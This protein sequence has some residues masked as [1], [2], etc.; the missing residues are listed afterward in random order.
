M[1]A[2]LWPLTT[3]NRI[4][5]FGDKGPT[6][7]RRSSMLLTS[8]VRSFRQSLLSKR[9]VRRGQSLQSQNWMAAADR[10][11]TGLATRTESLEERTLLTAFVIDQAFVNS[12]SGVINITNTTIDVNND[13]TP[14]FDSIV[15]D[16]VSFNG[17]AGRGIN[18]NLSD[19][20]LDRISIDELNITGTQ[21]S[22]VDITLN[23]VTL[24]S[25][26][27]QKSNIASSVGGGIDLNLTD[28]VL[29]VLSVYQST[30][31]V[32]NGTGLDINIASQTRNSR[33]GELDISESVIDGVSI[34]GSGL[35]QSVFT[36]SG[37][38]P[39]ALTVVDH[40]LQDGTEVTVTGVQGLT[41]A[42]TI[43]TITGV[44]ENVFT[45]DSTDGSGQFYS[46]GGT[47]TVFTTVNNIRITDNTIGISTGAGGVDISLN[48]TR[49]PGLII[50]GNASIRGISIS[51][52]DSPIDGLTV[53]D[54]T[55]D[56]T[57]PQAD[58]LSFDLVDSTLTNLLIDNNMIAGDATSGGNGVVFTAVD[59]N[60]YGSFTRTTVDR[61]LGNALSFSATSTPAFL[62]T[63]RGPLVFDFNSF[64]AETALTA[65][66]NSTSTTLVVADGRS[67]QPQQVILVGNEQMFISAVSRNTLTV[68]RGERGTLA[69]SHRVTDV[70]R[71][72]TSSASGVAR[73]VSGNTFSQNAGA[74]LF[75]DLAAGTSINAD[76]RG[77]VFS[78]NQSRA[79]DVTVRETHAATTQ[80]ARGG[81][82]RTGGTLRVTDASVFSDF[83]FPFNVMVEGEEFTVSAIDRNDLT[84]SRGV[85]E[86]FASLHDSNVDVI[87]VQ[88]DALR[89][90]IGGESSGD[91]N[92]LTDNNNGSIQVTLQ[93]N[94]AGSFDIRNNV[95]TGTTGVEADGIAINLTSVDVD[96][97]AENILRR[98]IIDSNLIGVGSFTTLRANLPAGQNVLTVADASAFSNGQN[99]RIDGEV[100]RINSITG[101]T[102]SVTRAVQVPGFRQTANSA[103]LA[104]AI[105]MPLTGA[106]LDRGIDF[107]FQELSAIED[108]HITNNIV[109]NNGDDGIRFFREDD[110]V[111]RTVN[112]LVGQTTAVTISGNTVSGNATN[113]DVDTNIDETE[114][115]LEYFAAG[116]EIQVLNGTLDVFD[117]TISDNGI[118]AN[119]RMGGLPVPNSPIR[120]ASNVPLDYSQISGVNLRAEADA[121]IVANLVGNRIQFNQ[122]DGV[123]QSD[124]NN[125]GSDL[126]DV[127]ATYLTNV[128]SDN[129]EDGI[130][131]DSAVGVTQV[132]VI[133]REGVDSNGLSLGNDISAN[134]RFGVHFSAGSSGA[135]ASI[136]NNT[137]TR[138]GRILANA[139]GNDTTATNLS[140]SLVF[141]SGIE[142]EVSASVAIKANTIESNN[143]AGIDINGGGEFSVRNNTIQF[144]QNDGLELFGSTDVVVL[145]NLI[146]SNVGRGVDILLAG[147]G[148]SNVQIGDGSES[149][150]NRVI[151]N[152]R[153]AIY[154]VSTADG[155]QNQNVEAT[156]Q[157][158]SNGGVGSG[159][160]AVLHVDTN[161]IENNGAGT[162]FGAAG[163]IV[164]Q[165]STQGNSNN[166][167]ENYTG[168]PTGYG[169]P[170]DLGPNSRTNTRVV[171]NSFDGN[172][173]DDVRFDTFRS[174]VDPLT[175]G[176]PINNVIARWTDVVFGI[177]AGEYYSDP[178]AR[179]NV[180]FEGNVGHGLNATSGGGGYSNREAVFKS[181]DR[182]DNPDHGDQDDTTPGNPISNRGPW[183][184]GG[185]RGRSILQVPSRGTQI[186][187]EN[188]GA[189]PA[190]DAV[191]G[192]TDV[193]PVNVA[194]G[195]TELEVTLG[196]DFFGVYGGVIPFNDGDFVEIEGVNAV[197]GGIHTA[198]G[199]YQVD[200][201]DP[202]MAGVGGARIR[203]RNTTNDNG[204]AYQGGGVLY[205]QLNTSGG[206]IFTTTDSFMYPG[207][208]ASTLRIAQG[209]DTAGSAPSDQF[210]SGSNFSPGTWG[211]WSP[212]PSRIGSISSI[213]ADPS[214][215][216]SRMLV[217]VPNHLMG[218]NRQVTITGVE[219]I[220][221]ANGTFQITIVDANTIS[222]PRG[223]NGTYVSG[224]SYE[225]IDDSFPLPDVPTFPQ[226][227]VIDITPDPRVSNTGIVTLTFSEEVTNVDIDDLF[228]T[229]DGV[230]IDTSGLFVQQ[231]SLSQYQVDF[232]SVTGLE[233]QYSLRIDSE[234]PEA[235]FVRVSPNPRLTPVENVSVNFTEDV[236]GV[237][238][239]DFTLL[240][241][242][243]D[244]NGFQPVDLSEVGANLAVFPVTPSQYTV[245]VSSV[246]GAEGSYRLRLNAPRSINIASVAVNMAG[247]I[248]IN[249]VAHGLSTGQ[250]L[251]ISGTRGA[252]LGTAT[253]LN[254]TYR[255][256]V[257]DDDNF[258]LSS[259]GTLSTALSADDTGYLISNSSFA[260]DSGIVD[261]VGR[262]YS[263]TSLGVDAS[264]TVTWVRGSLAPSA[265]IV[266]VDP[267]PRSTAVDSVRVVFSEPVVVGN[268]NVSDFRLSR[269]IGSGQF[270]VS[271]SGATV[272]AIDDPGNG[273]ATTFVL[274]GLAAL[275]DGF[276]DYRLTLITNDSTRIQDQQGQF[277]TFP[278]L[279]SW[280]M[281]V[282]EPRADIIDVFPDPRTT[283]AG[284]VQFV[285]NG[286]DVT[287]VD[288]LNAAAHFTLTRDTGNGPVP[289]PLAGIPITSNTPSAYSLDLSSV[290][291]DGLGDPIDG[292]YVLTLNPGTGI[293]LVSTGAPLAV[294]SADTWIQD[295]TGPR[296]EILDI[297]PNPRV[298]HAGAVTIQ[299]DEPV[300]GVDVFNAATDFSLTRD[301]NDGNGP[302]PVSLVG[303]R[304]R[305]INSVDSQGASVLPFSGGTVFAQSY[306]LDLSRQGL[307]DIDGTYVL[308]LRDTGSIS[309]ATG[310]AYVFDANATDTWVLVP[311]QANDIIED[312]VF[313]GNPVTLDSFDLWF[314]DTTAPFVV[315]G[316]VTVDPDPRSTAVGIVTVNFSEP[317]TG[318]NLTDFVL[319]RDAI[320][321]PLTALA[322]TQVSPSRYTIDL[323]LVTGAAGNYTLSI[324]RTNSLIQD[325][326]G[327]PIQNGLIVLDSWTV[328]N[329]GPTAA[330]SIT[331]NPRTTPANNLVVN[332]TKPVDVTQ[333]GLSDFRLEI[334]LGDGF[335]EIPITGGSVTPSGGGAFEDT[336]TVDLSADT[337][338]EAI[339]R[340][341]LVASDSEITDQAGIELG[342]DAG[343][344]FSIDNTLPLADI[345]DIAPDP[346]NAAVGLVNI[347]FNE[348]VS[349]LDLA[350]AETDFDLLFDDGLGGGPVLVSLAS[351][352]VRQETQ[353]RYTIDLASV[354]S[355][356]GSY[357][358]RL[359]SNTGIA[360]I[361]GNALED[362]LLG[363]SNVAALDT[364]FSG[365]DIV[366]PT[367][368]IVDV[369]TPRNTSAGV[370]TINFSEDVSGVDLA[371]FTLTRDE[372]LGAGPQPV[373]IS[374]VSLKNAPGSV[375]QYLLDL[376]DVTFT[377]GTFTLSVVTTDTLSPI[378]D[379]SGNP[380]AV[381][382][383]NTW[384]STL[385]DLSAMIVPVDPDPRLRSAGIVT[386]NFSEAVSGVGLEDFR[387]TRDTGAGPLLV[388]LRG[389]TLAQS[390]S[391]ADQYSI[392]L[393]S[394]TGTD[395]I[396]RLTLRAE[397]S[398]IQSLATGDVLLS[399]VFDEWQT[400]TTITVNTTS[401]TVDVNPG[402][403]VVA[404]S[405]NMISLRAA[406]MESGALPGDDTIN[407]PAGNYT[408]SIGGIGEQFAASGDLDITDTTGTL[409][410]LGAGADVTT[411]D[412]ASIERIFH[413]TSGA[414]LILDGVTI[415]GGQVRGSED[416]GGIRN[417]GGTVTIRNSVI[418]GNRSLDDGG[419][420]DNAGVMTLVDTTVSGNVATNNG[421]GIRNVGNLTI[422][423]STIGGV[424][425]PVAMTDTRNTAG[426]NGGGIINLD[427]GTITIANST[428][429]G[430]R[431]T[432]GSGGG[433]FNSG[434]GSLTNVTIASN[435][436]GQRGGGVSASGGSMTVQ[437]TIIAGNTAISGGNDVSV[438]GAASALVSV[439]NNLVQDINGAVGVFS[440]ANDLNANPN[441]GSLQ[442][443]GGSTFT[444]A[445]T[446]SSPAVD[447]GAATSASTD[448]RGIPRVLGNGFTDIGAFEFGGFFVDSTADSVDVNPGDGV[449]SDNFGRVTLR[450][451]I[452]EANALASSGLS[453]ANA[454]LLGTTT[455]DLSLTEI[456]T[457][458]PTVDVVDITPDPLGDAM[459]GLDP[460]DEIV[461][462]FDE[463]VL[464]VDL[465]DF[466]LT[467]EDGQG[468]VTTPSLA[469]AVLTQDPVDRTRYTISGL[470]NV[471]SSDGRYTFDVLVSDITDFALIPLA[472]D[473][474]QIGSGIAAS[475]QFV[476]GADVFAPTALLSQVT[477]AARTTNPGI[478]ILT[479]SEDVFGVST[480]AGAPNFMLTY[481]DGL[482][483][484]AV[485]VPL[486]GVAVQL[487]SL[488]EYQ[489]D[490]S[491][492]TAFNGLTDPGT[493]VLTFDGTATVIQDAA[494]NV[495]AGTDS[496][497]WVVAVD[498][499]APVGTIEPVTPDPRIGFVGVVTVNFDEPVTGVDL[500][501]AET[502]FNLTFD[503]DLAGGMVPVSVDLSGLVVTRVS[504]TQY[505]I[506]LTTV[507]AADGAYVF[508]L[509]P[510]GGAITDFALPANSLA[511]SATDSWIVGE[512]SAAFG[513]LDV[514]NG[515]LTII[516]VGAGSSIVDANQIDR[517]FDVASGVTFNLVDLTVTG[518]SV[519]GGK[520][521]GGV[522]SN[523]TVSL[524]G[525]SIS[526]NAA[527]RNG[528]GIFTNGSLAIVDSFVDGNTAGFGGG[529][530]NDD[531]SVSITDSTFAFNSAL[532]DG[533]GLF[534]DRNATV[535]IDGSALT[536]NMAG[537]DGGGLYNNDSGTVT[538]VDSAI[539]RNTAD[540][541]GGGLYNELAANATLTNSTVAF[542]TATDGGGVFNQDGVVTVSTSSVSG[543]TATNDGGGLFVTSNGVVNS[544][545]SLFSG[546]LAIFNGGGIANSGTV[547]LE[548]VRVVDNTADGSG[549][550]ISNNRILALDAS[551]VSGN[552]AFVNGGGIAIRGIGSLTLTSSA[553][554]ENTASV[555]GGGIFLSDVANL[556]TTFSTIDSN[557][558]TGFGGGVYQ[559]STGVVTFTSSTISRN[560]ASVGGGIFSSKGYSLL[561]STLS[562]NSATGNGGG[563]NNN[564]GTVSLES[565]TVFANVAGGQGGG[566]HNA[567]VFGPV[568]LRNTI[569]A[570]NTGSS[571][572]D[573]SGVQFT[574]LGNNLVGDRGSV[575]SFVNGT[576]GDIVGTTGS[577]ID[578]LLG[579]LQNNG[580]ATNTHSLL[581]GSP[582]RD[583]GSN[584]GVSATDQRGF[585]RIFDGDGNGVA[586]VD[587]GAFESG[588]T[589]NTFADTVDVRP[590]DRSS[591]DVFG[592]SSLRAAV[593]EA[594][595]LP[596]DDT[597]LLIP[598]TY[599]LTTAGRDE[600]GALTGDL[601]VTDDLTIIGAG[602]NQTFIDAA[603]LDRIFHVLPGA[604]LDLQNLTIRNGE[605]LRGGAVLN[606]GT[607]NLN[608]VVV[609]TSTADIGGGL[610][611]DVL[612]DFLA[613]NISAAA[614]TL[615]LSNAAAFPAT[616]P[617]DI[618]IGTE[619]IRVTTV[620]GNT[621]TVTR[622]VNSTTPVVHVAGSPVTLV[623]SLSMTDS[624]VR[625]NTARLQGGGLFNRNELTLT[626]VTVSGNAS[627]AQGGGL[628]NTANAIIAGTTFDSNIADANGGAIYNNSGPLVTGRITLSGSTLSNNEAGTKGGGIY[629]NDIV[630]I[631]NS[632][633]SGNR[634]AA[635]GGGIY[636]A[637]DLSSG[638]IT[639]RNA[640][641]AGNT[642]D[643]FGGGIV[644]EGGT[645]V[646]VKN[647]IVS[648][649]VAIGVD[650]DLN[651]VFVSLGTNFIGDAGSSTGFVNGFRGDQAGSTLSPLDAV[652]GPLAD[653]GGPTF[654]HALLTG[655]PAID[656]ANNSGGEPV[657]QRGGRRPTDETADVGAF[658][659]QENRI[660]I[661]DVTQ[662][663]GAGGTTNFVFTVLLEA[664]TA[665]P[666][667]VDFTTI[668]DT[669]RN[670]EDFLPVSGT[671]SFA[672]GEL[673]Q[674]ITVA[675][676]GDTTPE[677]TEQFFVQLSNAVNGLLIDDLAIGTILNDDVIITVAPASTVA[678]TAETD[679]GVTTLT[680]VV[681]LLDPS[682]SPIASVNTIT[683]NF[684]TSDGTAVSTGANADYISTSGTLTF[685]PGV[686]SQTVD[687]MVF[688]DTDLEPDETVILNLSGASDSEGNTLAIADAMSSGLILNDET[689]ISIDSVSA[690]EGNSPTLTPFDFTVSL[691]Q[692]NANIVTVDVDALSGTAI[693]G[694]DFVANSTTVT[695]NPGETSKIVTVLIIGDGAFEADEQFTM[696][697][698]NPTESGV[699][700]PTA[701]LS[702]P[703]TGTILNDEAPPVNWL[704]T[705][706]VAMD[707]L[708]VFKDTGTGPVLF[709]S[710]TD[711]N[712]AFAVTADTGTQ[713]D[714]F[715]ID[716]ANGAPIPTL[717][718]TIDGA[719]EIGGDSIIIVN[720]S[721]TDIVYTSTDATSGT[722]DFD[723]QVITY[724]DFEPITDSL[725]A[726]NRTFNIS[727]A[728]GHTI[729]LTDDTSMAGHSRIDSNGMAQFE[730]VSFS[731]PTAS[732]TVTGS[733]DG[734]SFLVETLDAAFAGSILINAGDGDDSVDATTSTENLVVSGGAGRD[735]LKGGLGDDT[736]YGG[737][738]ADD[739]QGN[740]GDD[741]LVGGFGVAN[742]TIDGGVGNDILRGGDG[743]D[744]LLGGADDDLLMGG[745]GNDVL[746]GG[747]GLDNLQG[748]NG[749]DTLA[750][751]QDADVLN[752]GS[753]D[754][755]VLGGLGTDVLDGGTG[756][757]TVD[758]GEDD[759][760]VRGGGGNDSV[761][762]GDGD[763]LVRGHAGDDTLSGGAGVDD[764]D[765]GADTDAVKESANGA[766]T[767]TLRNFTLT[768]GALSEAFR[769]VE[770]FDLTSGPLSSLLDASAYTRGDVT[771]RGLGGNDTLLGSTGNDSLIGNLGDDSILGNFGNDDLI[772]GAGKDTLRGG[773]GDDVL[774]GNGGDDLLNGDRG[775]DIADGKEGDDIVIGGQGADI[776]RGGS[777][778]DTVSGGIGNDTVSGDSGNDVLD[779]G[780]DDDVLFGGDDA[781]TLNGGAGNDRLFGGNGNDVVNGGD[782]NDLVS[783]DGGDDLLDGQAGN[784]T[785]L[786][787]A[788]ADRLLGGIDIDF[789]DGGGS[790]LDEVVLTGTAGNDTFTLSPFGLYG[791]L[792]KTS[793]TTFIAN[794]RN[795][796][797]IQL[798][799]LDGDDTITSGDASALGS[800]QLIVD[801]GAG[802]DSIDLTGS[803]N[804]QLRLVAE[805]STGADTISGG[806]GSDTIDGGGGNDV[807]TGNA[808]FDS[809]DGGDGNDTISGGNGNDVLNGRNDAD[810]ITGGD[811]SDTISGGSGNDSLD[812][813]TGADTILGGSGNDRIAGRD[814]DDNLVGE[815]GSD[816]IIGEGGADTIDGSAGTDLI[817]GGAGNDFI[818]GGFDSDTLLGGDGNDTLLGAAGADLL[819]GMAG[820]DRLRGQGTSFD[821]L[822][823]GTGNGDD[824]PGDTYDNPAEIDNTFMLDATLLSL[825]NF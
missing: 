808:G 237:D 88:G 22:G 671:V 466:R 6:K 421:G 412:A 46:S 142:I 336:F 706:N 390:P 429:S 206:G 715:T 598:G 259:D 228:L 30:I 4:S 303:V 821:T 504:D 368:D 201:V 375:S 539:T 677:P 209:A 665:E 450:A 43:D 129:D 378:V 555:N 307:T 444:H 260:Y 683:V 194:N 294:I 784:D 757:D 360:D 190:P 318:V 79:I 214:A 820:D 771:L 530:F 516:G 811:G 70:V 569:V 536:G 305:A 425:D 702:G 18:I 16:T 170:D 789:L 642:T 13:G 172:F 382:D 222:I 476:R 86:T 240:R 187:D 355:A 640:T 481:D 171:N 802:D 315:P 117:V 334:D 17:A 601:D 330:L 288:L 679:S 264:A 300:Q 535:N 33:I 509:D 760:T 460:I 384:V 391:G 151:G 722:I 239:F 54:T 251:A 752:G 594:N 357:E 132:A 205:F 247:E 766:E 58:A 584:V 329:V 304:V 566:I 615:T 112:P 393:G 182:L 236:S 800:A 184:D 352:T 374:D 146:S 622:G 173:G 140:N 587:I 694:S 36:A 527:D 100:V 633:L 235:S 351:L 349:G 152:Q 48:D 534:N 278:A 468:A 483:G 710:T 418:T 358:L 124:R 474:A 266:D 636:N 428:I 673:A 9:R 726:V 221:A 295:S 562:T 713:D 489:L 561:N 791:R 630:T 276:G 175:T 447:A 345:V 350:N 246:S 427:G 431:V 39:L 643:G 822:V 272:T 777:G 109:A 505:T 688:G 267:D 672:P 407:L 449:V 156:V 122:V 463:P 608:N 84:V 574:S 778:D 289:V 186:P 767:I 150:R 162:G 53:R 20:T 331:P 92:T 387:L 410:I 158:L 511:V 559:S 629:N 612:Q 353:R 248:A 714:V 167:F 105:V 573:V 635:T 141:G 779:G 441:L 769:S 213:I 362:A 782:G 200:I 634:A 810:V 705:L 185:T 118:F 14:E 658:E 647:T 772:G 684:A 813:G 257:D 768:I 5:Q 414:T 737:V 593:M 804:L 19:L 656:A 381:G 365:I 654:T 63:N 254:G 135:R 144:N 703:G 386:V 666:I 110:G 604:R 585:A 470:T 415:T 646:S 125:S 90:A 686:T 438:P 556:T 568:R 210:E 316:T 55:I 321:I 416:G 442:D 262:P 87:A 805:G 533:G 524:S 773:F 588:F 682:G 723:G 409:T 547:N 139:V 332:F 155:A 794:I 11:A 753:G 618:R 751:D 177:G 392:D 626:R 119:E 554:S 687:V 123:H 157:L 179:M 558:A 130:D 557:S 218:N 212:N 605:A 595:A 338:A 74:G 342:A 233:G 269:D 651:G 717:G 497:T 2:N 501:N 577:A 632:T 704:V 367:V 370:V 549:G 461:V 446:L 607:L 728:G 486:S 160:N 518:G 290:T 550:G 165:G 73:N 616:G 302:Q 479:F 72:V 111:A 178:L 224:G 137:I 83:L 249:A 762:G 661:G 793:G 578:P 183:P 15:V 628:Y 730:S 727:H 75:T 369:G 21:G 366:D 500:A 472:E 681:E 44:D 693:S 296:A 107:F 333:V 663:E 417:D 809:I 280:T 261:A 309:D 517:V 243:A 620:V 270:P 781:D 485:A 356:Q 217:T 488:S 645:S 3:P 765:G 641:I 32:T 582:A 64:T 631:V 719:D 202:G 337:A 763:D 166:Y 542:N 451:A 399:D 716:F 576:G 147:G 744:S 61:T 223:I 482:G 754:D 34:A 133:G 565:T 433:L 436:A 293:S 512:D 198:N 297:D 52:D 603:D 551:T 282:D 807:L 29:P 134:G 299:F 291:S 787:G 143:G 405:G 806:N 35:Q 579:V 59:S 188:D 10:A 669:A 250:S 31:L 571:N 397:G 701:V 354:T 37:T 580:G 364:W 102:L 696:Q 513:D 401:D 317:V 104:G 711:L 796:E 292:V 195:V 279:E 795:T 226:S 197:G 467:F 816:T 379:A 373:D 814:G 216:F 670:G 93:D 265:D 80:I 148:R 458:A 81:I 306:V 678:R 606:G 552:S 242:V 99:V 746:R 520:D 525:A 477:P 610:Y 490:L 596:G 609:E 522:R 817:G 668:Q 570:R 89:L 780:V 510:S 232:S 560:M 736:I 394:V 359:V 785:V 376:S 443:N 159:G 456:D 320:N 91:G 639:I 225:T 430:N 469:G 770:R 583:A 1:S 71:S 168:T 402:D 491:A 287:G 507:T 40:G 313:A 101:N 255:V 69:T 283:A 493:Y 60:V 85:N 735:T 614:S 241:D 514:T 761:S 627:H 65:A 51:L 203:L 445:L 815:D 825:L 361:A 699:A 116:I 49:A 480:S 114:L 506:D 204:P 664:S 495:F 592:S 685:D 718:L 169:S 589:V 400:I 453:V 380:L 599:R 750:G 189:N 755:S 597:I 154:Y 113:P 538:I 439:D 308:S 38:N 215:P 244:G 591:A 823:G 271:L 432:F 348:A 50:E 94:A 543:N 192:I 82:S 435:S 256:I 396:Y 659:V 660:S 8:W 521:G 191:F 745:N 600:D 531:G 652:I 572:V 253:T 471:L 327:N 411:I 792:V 709:S 812:G 475:D 145:G 95:I 733:A 389:V 644:A 537:R 741:I 404:D 344:T 325:M 797:Q 98:S 434:S 77:N 311:K 676:N 788:G 326:S 708:Q 613:V 563:L 492:I 103:H 149:G 674:T 56:A 519:T 756:D 496:T 732:L 263:V 310:N 67:F 385:I 335:V 775:N 211:G 62:T 590:G 7:A 690:F 503:A 108:I 419:A 564:G 383:S 499:T 78:Q 339:Y 413:I 667:T 153:E 28:V 619:E 245:D 748:E 163:L 707:T 180:V 743:D 776:V 508:T 12:Q 457:T 395:G 42:N 328:E 377:Q 138:N 544:S 66:V 764:L 199:V 423:N 581:F 739:I 637:D 388:S 268:V 548:T 529:V 818:I 219:G 494:G 729:R 532:T 347:L 698:S 284:T 312:V 617:F 41:A 437:N 420:I 747:F 515:S 502:D 697:L 319:T 803:M 824:S 680:F 567:S 372:G 341:T 343:T 196:A 724:T 759:D 285:F 801:L 76:V 252:T 738:D 324:Q 731:N 128:I 691:V 545:G 229:R 258:R 281:I 799:T 655:S 127:S 473:P 301:I 47:V 625:N 273:L 749:N 662:V 689:S 465:S 97:E 45:L 164:R 523:G 487:N 121:R 649:N 230:P 586:T 498:V 24:N 675:V 790:T 462:Q 454:I 220:P 363:P 602:R 298:Q 798:N 161:T 227:D 371:D 484:G 314:A 721:A 819:F 231:I 783:G 692:P 131:F 346:R 786:G 624:I 115:E 27:V 57:R 464:Q 541:D 403:G 546:N 424:V 638:T 553:V 208:G 695:F 323:N 611:N 25:L 653:N 274:D 459:S 440:G 478:V 448:Q 700:D 742:D 740:E 648:G 322:V 238:I 575:V 621:Y 234:L 398:D 340:V 422:I 120:G 286:G 455:Y 174:T 96:V 540:G 23:N 657:D 774:I 408:L 406:I 650:D 528:G 526:L 193:Q 277:L 758:G 126:R 26:V 275:T 712:A 176:L 725:T 623:Q 452:M 734:D 68:V 136:S 207:T 181:R 426:L 720:G 106:N